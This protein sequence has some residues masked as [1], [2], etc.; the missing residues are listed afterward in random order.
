MPQVRAEYL[1]EMREMADMTQARS[2]RPWGTPA[3]YLGDRKWFRGRSSVFRN[4][5]WFGPGATPDSAGPCNPPRACSRPG[6]GRAGVGGGARSCA[7]RGAG[8]ARVSFACP[9]FGLTPLRWAKY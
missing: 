9:R 5:R 6:G 4:P 7:I 2:P 1:A 3:A 8:R